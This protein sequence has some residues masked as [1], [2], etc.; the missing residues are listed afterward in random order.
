MVQD[1]VI[2]PNVNS[3]VDNSFAGLKVAGSLFLNPY[4]ASLVLRNDTSVDKCTMFVTA[5][6]SSGAL[7]AGIT[8]VGGN[9]S[10]KNSIV[11]GGVIRAPQGKSYGPANTQFATLGN[12]T[13]LSASMVDPLFTSNVASYGSDVAF[14][15]LRNASF[16]LKTG[17][18]ATG[19]GA[20]VTSVKDVQARSQ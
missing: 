11:Y 5:R 6:N 3:G 20:V 4:G 18:P 14:A 17:S 16:K 13:A 1:C 15:T 10:I 8:D 9:N 2:G 12:T 7:H 19:T